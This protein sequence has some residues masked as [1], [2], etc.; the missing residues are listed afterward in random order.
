MTEGAGQLSSRDGL[1]QTPQ[2][3]QLGSPRIR[4]GSVFRVC[5]LLGFRSPFTTDPRPNVVLR[6]SMPDLA[7]DGIPR[8]RVVSWYPVV[9]GTMAGF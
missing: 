2:P 4:T 5:A 6:E 7:H 1:S 8:R 9:V 3:V